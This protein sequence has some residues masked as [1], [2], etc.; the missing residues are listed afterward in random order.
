MK[1]RSTKAKKNDIVLH[2]GDTWRVLDRKYDTY[3]CQSFYQLKRG[4]KGTSTFETK[5]ARSDSFHMA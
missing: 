5:W 1:R 4:R 3:R 2:N